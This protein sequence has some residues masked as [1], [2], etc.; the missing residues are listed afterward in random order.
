MVQDQKVLPEM[1]NQPLLPRLFSAIK[2]SEM[3]PEIPPE[4][5]AETSFEISTKMRVDNFRNTGRI[6]FEICPE[7]PS[8]ILS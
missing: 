5:H 4:V 2:P 8:E 1:Q 7:I 6:P 3:P